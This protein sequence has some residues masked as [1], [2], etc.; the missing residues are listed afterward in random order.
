MM[1]LIAKAALRWLSREPPLA[2]RGVVVLVVLLLHLFN[3]SPSLSRLPNL[4]LCQALPVTLEKHKWRH[5]VSESMRDN[6]CL[7]LT[8]TGTSVLHR[9]VATREKVF[10]TT[11]T[12]RTAADKTGALR[13]FF[14]GH[15]SIF[16]SGVWVR[17]QSV[18][19]TRWTRR[20]SL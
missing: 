11:P 15:S 1:T 8:A 13:V 5:Q 6:S 12:C 17:R 7:Q 9:K 10:T 14:P 3:E 2:G 16:D 4:H 20:Q 19:Q 18:R